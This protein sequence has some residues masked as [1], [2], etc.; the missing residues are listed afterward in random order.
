MKVLHVCGTFPPAYAYGGPPRSVENLT[1]ALVDAGHD[2]TVYTTDAKDAQKR[3]KD[4]DNP[5]IRN[6]VKVFRFRNVNNSLAWKNIQVPPRMLSSLLTNIGEFDVVHTHEFRSPPTVFAHLAAKVRNVPHVHQPRGS[7]PRFEMS[8][9][10]RV[11]DSVIGKRLLSSVDRV[12]ASSNTESSKYSDV[13]PSLK[14][15]NISHVPNGISEGEY[16]D[17]PKIGNF[18][19]EYGIEEQEHLILFLSRLHPRK[20][21][22]ILIDA[23]SN[24]SNESVRLVFVGPNEG[25]QSQW[26]TRADDNGITD[27]VLFTGPRYGSDKL[28]AY[29][30]ADVFVLPSKN[31]Y[32]S[33]GNVVLEAMACGTPIVCTNVCGVS[34]WIEHT[35][36]RVTKAE[37]EDLA[38][39]ISDV[40]LEN[41]EQGE[42]REYVFENF[43]WENIAE[44]TENVYLDVRK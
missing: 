16:R 34:E 15:E 19:R 27:Q 12:I 32:E 10:K 20:G 8:K 2:V 7:V 33:F 39:G 29:V 14:L 36:C 24:L 28:S 38:N 30:D 17:V 35:D 44:I 40:L 5:E 9:L 18:R 11:F 6:G 26:E 41:S 3:V 4:Y 25:A 21:G 22:D 42:L 43:N 1:S 13:F 31:E 37:A 23:V